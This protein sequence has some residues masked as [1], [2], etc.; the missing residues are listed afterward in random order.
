MKGAVDRRLINASKLVVIT[1]ERKNKHRLEKEIGLGEETKR[2]RMA[3]L[4]TDM[5][6]TIV[7]L[8]SHCKLNVLE[9]KH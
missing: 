7:M 5:F 9:I 4:V 2:R 8:L 6:G 1:E 3:I